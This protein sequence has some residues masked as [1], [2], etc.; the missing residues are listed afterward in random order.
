MSTD[1]SAC[2]CIGAQN[3]EPFCPCAM[4]TRGIFERDGKWIEPAAKEKILG[5]V[6]PS[7]DD[8]LEG[9]GK[10]GFEPMDVKQTCNDPSHSPPGLLHIPYGQ[11]YRHICPACGAEKVIKSSA[12][13]F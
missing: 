9:F 2:N 4:R 11:Q 6:I 7:M 1:N 5:S 10:G 8:L 12:V 3:G 13:T